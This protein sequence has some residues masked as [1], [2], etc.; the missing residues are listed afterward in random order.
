MNFLK[1]YFEKKITKFNTAFLSN[2]VT[3]RTDLIWKINLKNSLNLHDLKVYRKICFWMYHEK[4]DKKRDEKMR[5]KSKLNGQK[6]GQVP[7]ITNELK[8]KLFYK[9]NQLNSNFEFWCSFFRLQH[10]K[11]ECWILFKIIESIKFD[12][13]WFDAIKNRSQIAKKIVHSKKINFFH[14]KYL[15][16]Q[17]IV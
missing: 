8:I 10:L 4:S 11:F 16:V 9:I 14:F 13:I 1:M 6:I 12:M 5:R 17:K 3:Y 7:Q 2:S 15:L